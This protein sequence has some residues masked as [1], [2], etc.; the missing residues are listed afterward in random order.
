MASFTQALFIVML[1]ATSMASYT[2][3]RKIVS[4]GDSV[5][6]TGNGAF[7]FTKGLY[8]PPPYYKGRFSNGPTYME[9]AAAALNLTLDNRAVGGAT[10]DSSK[11]PAVYYLTATNA[12][13]PPSVVEQVTSYLKQTR[14]FNRE[15]TL[16]TIFVGG[17][18]DRINSQLQLNKTGT[19]VA[20]SVYK[21]WEALAKEGAS[22]ILTIVQP[23]QAPPFL[24]DY[25]LQLHKLAFKFK[26]CYPWVNLGLFE[27]AALASMVLT[28]PHAYGF[29]HGIFDFC[30]NGASLCS[31]PD[32]YMSFDSAPHPTAALH[33]LI[34]AG[35]V[36]FIRKW[37]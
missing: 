13:K 19:D 30:L 6:D 22:N 10:A 17:N 14:G 11:I 24:V 31:N 29:E 18:D 12:F 27:F 21:M 32:K 36:E 28:A 16:F 33:R 3:L 1:A 7:V 20:T 8:P 2:D 4:F 26:E 5:T 15:R 9:L 37:Y 25:N 35:F 34:S 23:F